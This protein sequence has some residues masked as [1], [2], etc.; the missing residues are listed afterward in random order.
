M[1]SHIKEDNY[2]GII[3]KG[4]K[5]RQNPPRNDR[6]ELDVHKLGWKPVTE[7]YCV[8]NTHLR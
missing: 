4:E 7:I 5:E 1:L 3:H 2:A 8:N 6:K